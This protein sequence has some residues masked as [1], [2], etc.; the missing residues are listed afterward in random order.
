[1]RHF[2]IDDFHTRSA[3]EQFQ[4]IDEFLVFDVKLMPR[5]DFRSPVWLPGE[6]LSMAHQRGPKAHARELFLAVKPIR[7]GQIAPVGVH[8]E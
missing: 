6:H 2:S 7:S 4:H 5:L 3:C 8:L 1:M